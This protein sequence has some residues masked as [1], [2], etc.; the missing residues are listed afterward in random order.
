MTALLCLL[1]GGLAAAVDFNKDIRPVLSDRC[2]ICHG[3]DAA[4]K[5][6]PLRLDSEASMF[7]ETA[8]RKAVVPGNV[9][10]S[11]LIQRI[12]ADKPA[13]RM[14]PVYSGLKLN[15]REI[16]LLR[17][18]VEEGA[19][20]QKHWSLIPPL[21]PPLPEIKDRR[22]VNAVDRIV[23]ARLE[24]E[25]LRLSAEA[26]K[27]A[28]IRRVSLDLTG[29]PPTPAEV[30]S[31]LA[32]NSP[33]AYEKL[34]DRLL[35]SPRY[36]ERM[37]ARWL[38]VAR[39]AD[40]NGYQ[41]DGERNMWRWRD[42]VIAAFN[43]N[44]PF[45]RF[46]V[47]QIAGDLLPGATRDQIIATGFNRN[48]RGNGEGG[49]VPEEYMVEYAADRVETM[50]TV[51]LGSTIGCARC[52]NHKYDPFT[53]KDFYS[54]FAYFNNIADR[55]RY[56]KFG[57]TPPL[58]PAPTPEQEE[59]LKK[60]D[61]AVMEAER[62]Y[63]SLQAKA[64]A[65]LKDWARGL[66]NAKPA[67]WSVSYGMK[68]HR[69]LESAKFNG[70]AYVDAGK[71]APFGYF[72]AFSISAWIKPEAATGSIVT[73][74]KDE[75]EE[76]GI[77]L[78][79]ENGKIICYLAARWLD[80]A[81]RLESK[82]SVALNQWT[83]ILLTYDGSRWASGVHIYVNGK[84]AALKVNLDELNQ[85]FRSGE[86]WR[87]GG[88]GGKEFLYRGMIED[89]RIYGRAMSSEEAGMMALRTSLNQ[90]AAA[91]TPA[92]EAKL[93]AAYLE[94]FGDADVR[95]AWKALLDARAQQAK[96]MASFPTVMVMREMDQRRPA[97]V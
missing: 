69:P 13:L 58:V 1:P 79:L 57:N 15:D 24:R 17:Q 68:I 5:K 28:L 33:G 41:T 21:S 77:L 9:A 76:Q 91:P 62:R 51:W 88:G 61:A 65:S 82:E 4:A 37:A 75:S 84:E 12:T 53:Q 73:K 81:L 36:G 48:H 8:G 71:E 30:K 59:G 34:V 67:N 25:G 56:F 54:L 89:V 49:I 50:S 64:D 27:P 26:D 10:K 7:A 78:G 63:A 22:A 35:A 16:A 93:R 29:L 83:H 43:R 60:Y 18:W 52:H 45:D 47:E 96:Y 95:D 23:I 14:P 2:F 19:K 32:D 70:T 87:I 97:H 3:P 39:Y 6:V 85:E 80:D 86:P 44:L 90:I 46:T 42:W 11:V 31:F 20:W 74:G 72:D 92:G 40:T 94:E 66:A 55:G 38:D